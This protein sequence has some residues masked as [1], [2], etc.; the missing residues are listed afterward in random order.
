MVG[1]NAA[2]VALAFS[3][4]AEEKAPE[5]NRPE[6]K[7]LRGAPEGSCEPF[8]VLV[9]NDRDEC[10]KRVIPAMKQDGYVV[11]NADRRGIFPALAGCRARLI[12]YGYGGKA[13]VTMSS[14]T[15]S[16]LQVC[17]QRGFY[18]LSGTVIEPRE[19][20]VGVRRGLNAA[21]VLAAAAAAVVCGIYSGEK[22]V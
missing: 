16:G 5:E 12:T 13:C 4:L 1:K 6:V 21:D 19:F 3:G 22:D 2:E 11:V 8:D 17:V 10:L 15:D 20:Y 14:V 7:V 18:S 9:I